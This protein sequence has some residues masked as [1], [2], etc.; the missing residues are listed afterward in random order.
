ME[1]CTALKSMPSTPTRR[2]RF[3][4]CECGDASDVDGW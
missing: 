2:I 4:G 3:A 1:P